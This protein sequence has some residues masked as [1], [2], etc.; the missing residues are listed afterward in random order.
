MSFYDV[1][2][3]VVWRGARAGMMCTGQAPPRAMRSDWRRS[4]AVSARAPPPAVVE[5]LVSY[6]DLYGGDTHNL[7]E[8]AKPRQ[9]LPAGPALVMRAPG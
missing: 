2:T 6:S 5:R 3:W 1:R 8:Y 7:R 9:P 4:A